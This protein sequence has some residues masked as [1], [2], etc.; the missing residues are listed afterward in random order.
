MI[1]PA[2]LQLA[3]FFL[4][5]FAFII[6]RRMVLSFNPYMEWAKNGKYSKTPPEK[7]VG[8]F[9]CPIKSEGKRQLSSFVYVPGKVEKIPKNVLYNYEHMYYNSITTKGGRHNIRFLG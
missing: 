7:R 4:C 3:G 2:N 6:K 8:L 9:F 1:K 5:L